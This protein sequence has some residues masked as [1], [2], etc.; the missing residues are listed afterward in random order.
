MVV[1]R[2]QSRVVSCRGY[3]HTF[4]RCVSEGAQ[5]VDHIAQRCVLPL[6]MCCGSCGCELMPGRDPRAARHAGAARVGAWRTAR[7]V[8][9][10]CRVCGLKERE[11]RGGA[12]PDP[13]DPRCRRRE[14]E[15][16][17]RWLP[18]GLPARHAMTGT[19]GRACGMNQTATGHGLINANAVHAACPRRASE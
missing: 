2:A 9:G 10:V 1:D 19:A 15:I 8:H 16:A 18:P 13:V 4:A 6:Q 5:P 11:G 14:R 12:A 7:R 3:E 17:V